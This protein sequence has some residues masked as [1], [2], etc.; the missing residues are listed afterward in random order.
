[1]MPSFDLAA[2]WPGR[3]VL[4]T[5]GLVE[6]DEELNRQVARRAEE[7]FDRIIVTGDLNYGIFK[8]IVSPEKLRHLE[9]K[10]EME[11]MLAEETRPGDLILFAN[12]AP[13]FV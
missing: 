6:A 7:I 5:P 10:S 4:I 1:M 11:Q 9:R 3:K 13:S 12:D 8:A 2:T